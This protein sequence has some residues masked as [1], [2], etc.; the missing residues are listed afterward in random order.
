[1]EASPI[2]LVY[3]VNLANNH[4][5]MNPSQNTANKKNIFTTTNI[6]MDADPKPECPPE[7][8]AHISIDSLQRIGD[9]IREWVTLKKTNNGQKS[10]IRVLEKALNHREA[11]ITELEKNLIKVKGERDDYEAGFNGQFVTLQDLEQRLTSLQGEL[12]AAHRQIDSMGRVLQAKP[13]LQTPYWHLN[14]Y[15]D[16]QIVHQVTIYEAPTE[17]FLQQMS[18]V[19][20]SNRITYTYVNH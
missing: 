13:D 16:G 1:M 10:H 6:A 20:K 5:T 12:R 14:F 7:A 8:L 2:A 11:H 17:L 4:D 9:I 18:E 15:R 3:A 19:Y